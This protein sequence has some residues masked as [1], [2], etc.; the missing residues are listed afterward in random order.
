VIERPLFQL[1][2][3]VYRAI[4]FRSVRQAGFAAYAKAVRSRVVET[5]VDGARYELHLGEMI[6]LA[7]YLQQFEPDVRAAIRRITKPGMTVLDI[8]ANIGAHTLLFSALVGSSGRVVAFE[9]TDFA[10]AKLAKNVSLNPD[11]AVE[12]VHMALADRTT[13]QQQ[14][15][16]RASW[17]TDGGRGNGPSIV[18]MM[19]LDDWADAHRLAGLDVIKLD[20]DGYEYPV[21]IGGT[22]TIARTRPTFI[23]EATRVHFADAAKNP[24]A[25]LRSLDYRFWDID[26]REL[27]TFDSLRERLARHD[28][29]FSLDRHDPAFS[30]NLVAKPAGA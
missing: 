23:I 25:V 28:P 5:D 10:Y 26:G 21:I 27:V 24:F 4:P 6:D 20:V 1:A 18:D 3:V 2:R 14:V 16:F 12:L 11:L 15:D 30:I 22:A 29:A 13:R 8:G 7:L 19:R 17:Q 9:P